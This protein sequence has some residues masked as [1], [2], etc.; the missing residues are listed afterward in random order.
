MFGGKV[1]GANTFSVADIKSAERHVAHRTV[2]F[3]LDQPLSDGGQWNMFI[4]LVGRH[5]LV[6]KAFMPE[7]NSASNSR[8]MNMVLRS[9]LREGARQ[10]RELHASGARLNELR[11]VKQDYLTALH[12]ILSIHLGTPPDCFSWQW[13]DTAG[14]FH[15]TDQMTPQ[16][17]ATKFVDLPLDEY[18]WLVHDPPPANVY[19]RTY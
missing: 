11:S 14:Q 8:R 5:G 9:K 10:I 2:A 17:F 16:D 7:T 19:G 13:R 6:P 18:V 12:R 15:R 1:G 4:N 3:L